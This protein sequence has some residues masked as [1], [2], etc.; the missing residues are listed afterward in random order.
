MQFIHHIIHPGIGRISKHIVV[1]VV[2]MNAGK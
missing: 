2:F 1:E